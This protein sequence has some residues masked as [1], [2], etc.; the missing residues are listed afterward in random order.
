MTGTSIKCVLWPEALKTKGQ[1]AADDRVV[2]AAGRLDGDGGSQT[3]V[4]DEVTPLEKAR[5]PDRVPAQGF[6]NGRTSGKALV[7]ELPRVNDFAALG[8]AVQHALVSNPGDCE[9]FIEMNLEDEGLVVRARAAQ[10]IRVFPSQR[11]HDALTSAGA[12]VRW[13]EMNSLN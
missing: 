5:V 9:V 13:M 8:E 1:D 4:C 7:I 2:L 11:L 10:F 3:F 6:R 12:R